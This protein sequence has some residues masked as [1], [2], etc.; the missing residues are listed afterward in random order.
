MVGASLVTDTI[1]L[2]TIV[3]LG[4]WKNNSNNY[5]LRPFITYSPIQTL[6][7][8]SY[9]QCLNSRTMGTIAIRHVQKWTF[10]GPNKY[11]GSVTYYVVHF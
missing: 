8:L 11:K 6:N 1:T 9:K 3:Q 4:Q 7:I 10:W 5:S 2:S